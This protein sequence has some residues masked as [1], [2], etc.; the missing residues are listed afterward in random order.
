MSRA[1]EQGGLTVKFRR[2]YESF[3]HA[4]RRC[5]NPSAEDFSAYGGRG[6]QFLFVSFAQF[7][8][9]LGPRPVGMTLDRIRN[10]GHYEPGN[11]RWANVVQQNNNMQ[12]TKKREGRIQTELNELLAEYALACSCGQ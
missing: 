4:R 8:E 11:V 5:E 2:E 6:I 7:L 12:R 10:E 3:K 1:N 9:V